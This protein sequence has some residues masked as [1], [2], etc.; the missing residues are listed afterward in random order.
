MQILVVDVGG[1]HV[2]ILRNY[3]FKKAAFLSLFCLSFRASTF[4]LAGLTRINS[5]KASSAFR[6]YRERSLR[7]S[8]DFISSPR[9]SH[10]Y[11]DLNFDG[12]YW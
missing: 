11:F 2:K 7:F 12:F 1:T 9:V 4:T 5:N 6:G 8:G 3:A 10:T